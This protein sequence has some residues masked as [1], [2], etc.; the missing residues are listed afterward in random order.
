MNPKMSNKT[1]SASFIVKIAISNRQ[2]LC[3]KCELWFNI[4][5]YADNVTIKES[6]FYDTVGVVGGAVRDRHPSFL[7]VAYRLFL[8]GPS[9]DVNH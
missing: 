2:S 8:I 7:H 4:N 5:S 1:V 9:R 3:H 6:C